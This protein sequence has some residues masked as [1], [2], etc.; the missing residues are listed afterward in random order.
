VREANFQLN[1]VGANAAQAIAVNC[2]RPKSG[3]VCT[4]K[5]LSPYQW[6]VAVTSQYRGSR[7]RPAQVRAVT[8]NASLGNAVR[9]IS[10]PLIED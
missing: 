7:L 4:L 6:S 3:E 10:V 5:Q 1:V 2:E 9:N 8:I